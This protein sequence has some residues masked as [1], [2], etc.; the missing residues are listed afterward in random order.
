MLYRKKEG[1]LPTFYWTR[2]SPFVTTP[3]HWG[4]KEPTPAELY[5]VMDRGRLDF[6]FKIGLY[7]PITEI[8]VFRNLFR[9]H[10]L[11][12]LKGTHLCP[13]QNTSPSWPVDSGGELHEAPNANL[14]FDRVVHCT[15]IRRSD[16]KRIAGP[17]PCSRW[18]EALKYIGDAND[19]DWIVEPERV[20]FI[21]DIL[22][23]K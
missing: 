4:P 20:R 9:L 13:Y 19:D 8:W 14:A 18:G 21:V 5:V 22:A 15:K 17:Y 23:F 10:N 11:Q 6:R 16:Q 12:Y 2:S 3:A 1:F 7:S